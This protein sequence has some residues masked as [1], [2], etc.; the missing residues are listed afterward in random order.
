M[1][2]REIN[3]KVT[4]EGQRGADGN[5]AAKNAQETAK[6]QKQ[7]LESLI[8][9]ISASKS[10]VEQQKLLR[11]A[12]QQSAK[13]LGDSNAQT[14]QLKTQLEK[15]NIAARKFNQIGKE[16]QNTWGKALTSYQFKFNAL[17]NIIAT[18][19]STISRG[20]VN[21]L[22]SVVNISADF[23]QQMSAVKAITG[24][25]SDE[26]NRL[27]RDAIRLGGATI[28]TS[29]E[30]G[31]LQE[32]YAK[33][34][35]ST[36]EILSATEATLSLAAATGEGLGES[37]QIAGSTLRA[38]Q[39]DA[40]QM[41]RV[42]DTM[43]KSFVTSALD[44]EKFR[45]SMKFIAPVARAAGFT[46]ED[47]TAILAKLADTGL[48]GS[49]AGT[50]LRNIMLRMVDSSS[51]LGKEAGGAQRG[52]EGLS[53]VFEKITEN[54]FDLT[55]ALELTDRRAV[56]AFATL[57][58]SIPEV[59]EIADELY[60][61]AGAANVMAETRMDNFAGSIEKLSGAWEAFVLNIN[62]SNSGLRVFADWLTKIVDGLNY[63]M[64]SKE[65]LFRFRGLELANDDI[66][67]FA[68]ALGETE[69]VAIAVDNAIQYTNDD[70]NKQKGFLKEVGDEIADLE[71]KMLLG[72]TMR[73]QRERKARKDAL[74]EQENLILITIE[75][76]K[77][78]IN[79]LQGFRE[80]EIKNREKAAGELRQRE[81]AE[82][83]RLLE[84]QKEANAKAI[85]EQNKFNDARQSAL[86]YANKLRIEAIKTSVVREL[87]EED[88]RYEKQLRQL[89]EYHA[90]GTL[91]TAEYLNGLGKAHELH[92]QK[93]LQV[94]KTD[95][96]NRAK[97]VNKGF[98]RIKDQTQQAIVS[99]SKRAISD[100]DQDR[101]NA[102]PDTQTMF[103][104]IF[105]NRED[106]EKIQAEFIDLFKTGLDEIGKYYDRQVEYADRAVQS[107]ER[108][109]D[110]LQR[111]LDREWQLMQE[112][113]ANNYSL[114][115]KELDDAKAAQEKAIL[116]QQEA[117]EKQQRV[118]QITQ[119]INLATA[120]SGVMKSL[121]TSLDPVTAFVLSGAAAA[122][123]IGA[124]GG[125]KNSIK[126]EVEQFGEGGEIRGK[127]HSQG[128]QLIEAE[129][130]EFVV[131]ASQYAK[132]KELVNAINN[133]KMNK[134]WQSVNRDLSVSLDD[135][136]TSRMLDRHF[137][138]Q[139]TQIPNGRIERYGNRTRV[140]RYA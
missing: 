110:Q 126:Q 38:F 2:E 70:L 19:T 121:F 30:V 131:K 41:T 103:E 39:M 48:Y 42:I 50:S 40:S 7:S 134:E 77:E 45:E 32:A 31:Q 16:G 93:M 26:F 15:V 72:G 133:D 116:I 11:K 82:Q 57:S 36:R 91:K 98:E 105:G 87:A 46:I 140:I 9:Q 51:K 67:A 75:R 55:K 132:Y 85:K 63:I 101:L 94:I 23:E 13:E 62:Q 3:V 24:A 97:E 5:E 139:V 22:K 20:F 137:G 25:T 59:R 118:E 34:G 35:F 68:A 119:T 49:L 53:N 10:V 123:I 79:L 129:G 112:G 66:K 52:L 84:D 1:A 17:G 21:A 109:V 80:D 124:F 18:V 100:A 114:R 27:R 107:S 96:E 28:F 76:N 14:I 8:A 102:L 104:L 120:I 12:V 65:D 122:G 117:L 138:R 99:E 136:R 4:V 90:D 71:K 113:Y 61:A 37:A 47:T 108:R 89:E 54:G 128:G 130:G 73:Q 88:F 58:Q 56:T 60:R 135:T 33:L 92:G 74:L 111:D 44:L 29:E 115:Q 64:T 43:A 83:N 127:K 69:D 95:F 81:L 86:D 125:F 78:Y 6:A 106:N